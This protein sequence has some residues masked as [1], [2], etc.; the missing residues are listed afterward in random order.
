MKV[1]IIGAGPTGMSLAWEILRAGDYEITIYDK[2]PSAGGSWW[3]PDVETRNLHAYRI[4]FDRAFLN[5]QSLFDEMGIKWDD[6]FQPVESDLYNFILKSLKLKD[7]GALTSLA[8][9]VLAKPQKYKGISLKDALGEIT[10]GGK[11][12]LEHLPLIMDG[13]TWDV[14]SAYEFV[15]SFDYVGLSKQYTQKVSG[16]VMCDAMQQALEDA[17]IKFQFEK[18][19]GGVEYFKHGYRVEFTDETVLEGGLLFLCLDNSPALKFLGDNWGP[20]AD[21]KLRASTYG[22]IN[23]IFDL[24]EP[25]KLKDDLE[26]AATTKLK[27]Q[28]AVLADGLTISCGIANLTEEIL[29]TPPEEL[30]D[31]VLAELDIPLPKAIRF[32]W[33]SKWDGKRWQFSQSSGVLSLHGQLPFYGECPYVAMCGMMSPR[34]TPYSSIEAAVEVSRSLGHICFGTREPLRPLLV[35][36]VTSLTLLVLIVL[37]LIYRNR[38]L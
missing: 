37:I 2:K 26:I 27:L 4:V 24:N 14:M 23:V 31:Q 28:P 22:S 38:N 30:R 13:V 5:T 9:R 33:G 17:G 1:H 6:I 19:L 12:I 25:V 18:E 36:Q 8:A 32:G 11:S 20:D 3:E 21:K 7:Y 35:T 16:K 29:T 15:K 34:E 10:E